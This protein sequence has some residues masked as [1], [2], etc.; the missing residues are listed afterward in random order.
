MRT[1]YDQKEIDQIKF[2]DNHIKM[3]KFIK[4]TQLTPMELQC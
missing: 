4:H 1:Y 3:I 2:K